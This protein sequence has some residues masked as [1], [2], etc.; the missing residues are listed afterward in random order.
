MNLRNR[1][2]INKHY[3]IGAQWRRNRQY[4]IAFTRSLVGTHRLFTEWRCRDIIP[5][6]V[7]RYVARV[8]GWVL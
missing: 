6:F 2:R 4:D 7:Q 1:I 8:H 3:R 5:P